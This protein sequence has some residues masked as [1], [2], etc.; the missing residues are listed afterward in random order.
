MNHDTNREDRIEHKPLRYYVDSNGLGWFGCNIEFIL[1]KK[2][3]ISCGSR[4]DPYGN[5]PCPCG[6]SEES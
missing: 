3:C 2:T 6:Q 5:M 1:P 4:S